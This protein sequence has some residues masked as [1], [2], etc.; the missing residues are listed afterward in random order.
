M[1]ELTIGANEA[2]QRFDKYLKKLFPDAPSGLLYGQLRK[3]NL[4]L[5]GKKAEGKE[6]LKEGDLVQ[7]FFSQET[8]DK[9]RGGANKARETSAYQKAYQKLQGIQV[10]YEDSHFIFL[11]KPAGILTQKASP[12]DLS[13]N[14]WMIGYLLD[15]GSLTEKE[16]ETF[17]PSVANRL[18]RNT[19]GLVLCGKS[20]VGLQILS[21]LIRDR[22]IQKFYQ[23]ICHGEMH[24]PQSLEGYLSKREATNQVTIF[25]RPTPGAT[26]IRTK[27]RPLAATKAYTFL[28][29]EL[30][31]GKTHQIRA[32]LASEGHSLLGD[33]KYGDSLTA[34]TD[35]K[36][37]GIR[38][39]L[40]HARH[41]V[42]PDKIELSLDSN[43]YDKALTPLLGKT[44]S[45][46]LPSEFLRI[47]K[48][49][50]SES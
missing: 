9:F 29:V 21:E 7:C 31:T 30:I 46:P 32:H 2:G 15:K 43:Q 37:F 10:L 50:F 19:S 23:C 36:E 5:N 22:K 25:D 40:L 6:L 8:F 4:T 24:Q 44:I 17:C 33:S 35:Q 28:E 41:I 16:L 14:E 48:K 38:H 42:F 20:L 13:L 3:K 45:A 47:E 1:Q 49:I 12:E 34:M 39:Q 11:N 27:Y 26:Q 18:D